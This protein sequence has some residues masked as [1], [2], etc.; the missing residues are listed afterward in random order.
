MNF[1]VNKPVRV[2]NHNG[3]LRMS[4]PNM[5]HTITEIND[6]DRLLYKEINYKEKENT[7]II[8]IQKIKGRN[9]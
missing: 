2:T 3:S 4:I 5:V 9:E 8:T 6:G 1:K 7:I